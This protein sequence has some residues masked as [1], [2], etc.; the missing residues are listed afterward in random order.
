MYISLCT[1]KENCMVFAW[2]EEKNKANRKKHGISFEEAVCV[3]NDEKL[4]EIYD[5]EHSDSEED[6]WYAVGTIGILIVVVFTIRNDSVRIISARKATNGEKNEY[7]KDYD[8]R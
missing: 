2:D 4:L 1:L 8:N 3:F 5:S 7:Y 6:R